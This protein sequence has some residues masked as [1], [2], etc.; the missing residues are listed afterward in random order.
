MKERA[1]AT[2]IYL[3]LS[4]TLSLSTGSPSPTNSLFNVHPLYLIPSPTHSDEGSIDVCGRWAG[5]E[6]R[7][8]DPVGVVGKNVVIAILGFVLFAGGNGKWLPVLHHLAKTLQEQA[9]RIAARLRGMDYN[10]CFDKGKLQERI[11]IRKDF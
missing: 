1:T 6:W 9:D 11:M 5:G 8:D 2:F 4:I 7:Q 10:Y 3:Y